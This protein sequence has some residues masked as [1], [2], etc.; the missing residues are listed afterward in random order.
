MT[1]RFGMMNLRSDRIQ[2]W[3]ILRYCL[4]IFLERLGKTTGASDV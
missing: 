2:S 4:S 3:L 1:V